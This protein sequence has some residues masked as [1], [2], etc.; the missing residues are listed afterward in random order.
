MIQYKNSTYKNLSLLNYPVLQTADILL[1]NS[2][3]VLIGND[4]R[5]HLELARK[6]AKAVNR[7][8]KKNIFNIPIPLIN[9]N[10]GTVK[11]LQSNLK[12]S[13]SG[14]DITDTI[15]LADT[16]DEIEHKII[17]AKTDS[18]DMIYFDEKN[19]PKLSNLLNIYA[20]L[21][22]K[23]IHEVSLKF[24]HKSYETFKRKLADE[25]IFKFKVLRANAEL[26]K[27][28][29]DGV[30]DFLETSRVT[31]QK[32]AKK[33]LIKLYSLLNLV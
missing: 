8:Y 13:K 10:I 2:N 6:I 9:R 33:N 30:K 26:L 7:M 17:K 27:K 14:A 11:G 29:Y 16:F 15:F 28:N 19:K 12:M 23:N 31:C 18:E 1:Y 20:S 24:K 3:Y 5:Q 25:I 32:I 21:C 4:Q 22:N